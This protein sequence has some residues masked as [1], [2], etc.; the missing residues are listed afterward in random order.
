LSEPGDNTTATIEGGPRGSRG[1]VVRIVVQV[2]GFLGGLAALGWC[3]KTAFKP[4]NREQFAKLSDAPASQI[5]TL[6]GL[7]LLTVILNGLAF[8]ISLAPVRRLRLLDVLATNGVCTFLGY[9][10]FKAG[11]IVRVII[12]N[13]RDKLPIATIGAWFTALAA[14]MAASFTVMCIVAV[15]Y[16]KIDLTWL[17]LTVAGCALTGT[18][19]V[20]T[21][22]YF[23]GERGIQRMERLVGLTRIA[24]LKKPLRWKVWLQLHD[25]F[26]MLASPGAVLGGMA[27]RIVDSGVQSMRFVI[28]A[29]IF[30]VELT[31]QQALLV[32]LVYFIVG[33]VSP[34]GLLGLREGG[35][36]VLGGKLLEQAG[37]N[38]DQS[39]EMLAAVALLVSATE[40]IAYLVAGGLGLAWLRP[41]RL[42]KLRK[43]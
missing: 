10:P 30:G 5:V 9:V 27:N 11:A 18:L 14:V 39:R 21:A 24:A 33:V 16:G 36:A 43:A 37:L 29:R 19:I 42:L 7:S 38:E 34:S 41:D 20:A 35:A 4:E 2:V 13:R 31:L 22:R 25:G 8:W 28:A 12:H 1:R 26:E 3:I 17:L 23:K 6:L 15:K 32:S 40:A